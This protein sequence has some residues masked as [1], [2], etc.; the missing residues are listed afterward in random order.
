M[1]FATASVVEFE[2]RFSIKAFVYTFIDADVTMRFFVMNINMICE[3]CSRIS[4]FGMFVK[5]CC[6]FQRQ[7]LIFINIELL[8]II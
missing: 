1:Y 2:L 7:C 8:I 5:L 3:H 6:P 4:L